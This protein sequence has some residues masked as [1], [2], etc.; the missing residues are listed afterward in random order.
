M[1]QM[2]LLQGRNR[3]TDIVH[4]CV[5]KVG[6]MNQEIEVDI[7]ILPRVKHTAS[8]KLLYGTRSSAQCS[9]MT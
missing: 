4:R 6:G 9:A 5:D 2:N 8:G 1:I 7:Y 3:D